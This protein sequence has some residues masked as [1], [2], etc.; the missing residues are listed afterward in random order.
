MVTSDGIV[1]VSQSYA[2]EIQQEPGGWGLEYALRTQAG[3]GCLSGVVNGINE[4]DWDPSIDSFL[5]R[6]YGLSD[7]SLVSSSQ[8]NLIRHALRL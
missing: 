6:K 8:P 5:P 3:K 7:F 1:T 2:E 4:Q